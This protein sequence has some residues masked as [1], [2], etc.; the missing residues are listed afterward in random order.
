M[1]YLPLA[2]LQAS[3]DVRSAMLAGY[4]DTDG[5]LDNGSYGKCLAHRPNLE[6][7]REI[8]ISLG[9][10]CAAI[11]DKDDP[12]NPV[13]TQ[14]QLSFTM[15]GPNLLKVQKYL[16]PRKRLPEGHTF[17]ETEQRGFVVN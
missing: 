9:I 6:V 17:T 15:S 12:C 16:L 4:L 1:I 7:A 3:E 11:L 10:R 14:P 5:W 13:S 2:L 8:A